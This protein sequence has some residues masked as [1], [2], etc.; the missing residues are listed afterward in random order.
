MHDYE[1]IE[2]RFDF[3]EADIREFRA[4]YNIAP[5]Q[6]SVVIAAGDDMKRLAMMRWGLIP[7][8]AKDESI[9]NRMINARSETVA[10]KRAFA[11]LLKKKR[12][13]VVADGFYEWRRD[14]KNKTKTPFRFTLK[15]GAPFAFAGLWDMWKNPDG[16]NVFSYTIITTVANEL[17]G[18]VHERMPV[19]LTPAAEREWLDRR[20]T[21]PGKLAAL[22][23]PADSG[24]MAAYEVSTVVNSPANDTPEC[25]RPVDEGGDSAPRELP[26]IG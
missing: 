9:G 22:L 20:I 25:I 18:E 6:E 14:K 4:R 26:L 8:W 17:V 3:D 24:A 7:F 16:E 1:F 10:E 12:C 15:D 2:D 5:T 21:E 23:S 19:I 11:G 13:L